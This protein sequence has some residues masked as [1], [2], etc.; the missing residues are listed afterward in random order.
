MPILTL[1]S[2]NKMNA[3]TK[4]P[5]LAL[6]ALSLVACT[7]RISFAVQP[8]PDDAA[9]RPDQVRT[10]IHISGVYPHL[11][12][13]GIYSQNGGHYKPGHDEC[14]IGAIVPWA[15]QL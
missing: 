15:N 14:G 7:G 11:T 6:F 8:Q 1:R 3:K 12:A 4:P 9:S 13:Y 5:H 10:D 2:K